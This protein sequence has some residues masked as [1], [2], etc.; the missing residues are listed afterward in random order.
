MKRLF[1]TLISLVMI[2]TCFSVPVQAA[3]DKLDV[4]I[5]VTGKYDKN[6]VVFEIETN[7]PDETVLM[8]SLSAGDYNKTSKY[9]GQTKVTI[10]NGKGKSEGFS[11]KGNKLS[12]DFDLSVSMSL[13]KLQSEAV[14][15]VIGKNGENM[16]GNAVE[17]ASV[18][19]SKVVRALF[20]VTLDKSVTITPEDD[21]SSTTFA[22]ETDKASDEDVKKITDQYSDADKEKEK[23]EKQIQA[24]IDEYYTYTKID[25]ITINPNLG[26][27]DEKD[28]IA[29]VN[30]TWEQKNTGKTSKKMLDMYS[31]DMAARVYEDLPEISELAVFWNVP[32]LKANA[33]ISFERKKNGM[34][35]SDTMFDKAFDK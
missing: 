1:A 19:S 3:N 25:S 13:P 15:K 35:Y 10:K 22:K 21:Y 33:K 16:T 20:A 34:A 27:D 6:A 11:N 7:L 30:L 29:L 12:G 32:Y 18:G 17:D 5:D 28:Y 14:Q 23:V 8:L 26:T 9:S 2:L 31:S 4:S 24:Y